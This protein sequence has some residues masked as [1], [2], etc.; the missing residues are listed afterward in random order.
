MGSPPFIVG[1]RAKESPLTGVAKGA[2]EITVIEL[3]T[4]FVGLFKN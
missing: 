1:F 3:P 4:L 2:W